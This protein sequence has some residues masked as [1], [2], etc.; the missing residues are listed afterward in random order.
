[1]LNRV[2]A[3][4]MQLANK[5]PSNPCHHYQSAGSVKPHSDTISG[6]ALGEGLIPGAGMDGVDLGTV[7]PWGGEVGEL[8]V[9]EA[10]GGFFCIKCWSS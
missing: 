6:A 1:M 8:E 5:A 3:M 4:Q 9:W 2:I 7:A 10:P